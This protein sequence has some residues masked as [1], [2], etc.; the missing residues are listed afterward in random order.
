MMECENSVSNVEAPRDRPPSS[1]RGS[2]QREPGIYFV[3]C[4]WMDFSDVQLHPMVRDVVA[5]GLTEDA[6]A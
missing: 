6:C 3:A 2:R 4:G 5:P 1:F